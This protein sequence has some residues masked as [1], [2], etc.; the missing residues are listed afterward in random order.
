M[1]GTR[2]IKQN[3]FYIQKTYFKN[4]SYTIRLTYRLYY[5]FVKYK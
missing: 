2:R 4:G 1:Q 3:N 5:S